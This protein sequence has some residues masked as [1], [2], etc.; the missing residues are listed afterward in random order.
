MNRF[1]ARLNIDQTVNDKLKFG[2]SIN[3]VYSLKN[4]VP[5]N[6]QFNSPLESNAIAPIIAIR[7][8]TGDYNDS[9]F[10]ANP[11]RAIAYSKD[12]STQLRNFSNIYGSW[13]IVKGLTFR[14]EAGIDV[15]SLYEYGWQGSKFPT[16][17]G[18]PSSGKYGTSRVINYNVNNTFTYSK[19]IND[20]H[21]FKLLVGQSFQKSATESSFQ[22]AQGIPNDNLQYLVSA[23]QNTSFNSSVTSFAYVSYFGRINYK[24]NNKYLVSA[25][26]RDDGSSRFGINTRYGWFPSASVGWILTEEQF[27][28]DLNIDR[29]INFFKLKGGIGKTGNSEIPNFAPSGAYN[30]TFFGNRG[31]L[32]PSQIPNKF[33]TWEKTT[34]TDLGVEYTFANNRISGGVDYY[35]KNTN[36]LLLNIPVPYTSGFGSAL[37][38]IGKMTN[39]GWDV[40]INTKN[41][42]GKLKWTTSFNIST[43]KNKVTDLNGQPILPTSRSLNAAVVGQPLGIFY[44]VEYAGVDP[45]NGDALFRLADG[46]TTNN[47]SKASQTTNYKVLGNPNPLHYGGITNSF[48]YMGFDLTVF[49]QWSYGNKTYLSSGVFQASGFTNFGLDNQTLDMLHYWKKDGDITNV[50]RPELDMNNGARTSGRYVSDGSYFRFKT[51]TF[52]YTLPRAVLDKFKI[53]S[54]KIY[55]TGQNLF[56]VTKY[57]GNDPEINYTAPNASTQTANLA[58]GIDYYSAPQAKSLIFGIKLGF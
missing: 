2:L 46:T 53:S 43:Y 31:G 45:L 42:V 50:P 55:A 41:L 16:S 47:W 14:S 20:V 11:F 32:Y 28:K 37:R 57:Q 6:N 12:K 39:R 36:A 9:T 24:F 34:Q 30:T 48:E 13:D 33:L 15:L 8:R 4:N 19:E 44:G 7:D 51:M 17:A 27:V 25:S 5:E 3:Q 21:S 56:T 35:I 58:N 22:Q 52:G 10:Y 18:T 40:Y 26:I 54:L 29:V 1:S 23:S 49:G 38:N